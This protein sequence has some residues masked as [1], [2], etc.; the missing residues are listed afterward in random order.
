MTLVVHTE[1]HLHSR[2]TNLSKLKPEGQGYACTVAPCRQKNMTH[3]GKVNY[4]VGRLSLEL[5][6]RDPTLADALL[7]ASWPRR[8]TPRGV[9]CC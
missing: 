8:R 6:Y 7:P 4:V 3:P 2:A 1:T 9:R 5:D